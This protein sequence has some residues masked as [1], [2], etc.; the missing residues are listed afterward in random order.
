[1]E[2]VVESGE[3]AATQFYG[4]HEK[5]VSMP[6]LFVAAD[7]APS[8]EPTI[9]D[10]QSRL[11]QTNA[12]IRFTDP[13]QAHFTL[14]F[15]GDV[16]R[17]AVPAIEKVVRNAVRGHG[18]F[19]V[20]VA[21]TGVFPS[22]DYISVV[23]VGV[24]E[25]EEPFR[26]LQRDIEERVVAEGIADEEEHDFVPHVTLGRMNSGRGK[27]AI[28]RFLERHDDVHVCDMTVSSVALKESEL[29]DDGSVHGTVFEADL[30]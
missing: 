18:P 5:P 25:G 3:S 26:A 23:W 27:S 16:A 29:H 21:G 19:D 14:K 2:T 1:M 6:R 17:D 7:L 28:R 12:D 8:A 22:E 9:K 20:T 30:G 24:S 15:I 11:A 10:L 4:D 13:T